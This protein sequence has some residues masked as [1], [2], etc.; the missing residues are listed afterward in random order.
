MTRERTKT[1]QWLP[2]IATDHVA[3]ENGLMDCR[4]EKEKKIGEMR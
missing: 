1:R 2:R 4:I 3:A